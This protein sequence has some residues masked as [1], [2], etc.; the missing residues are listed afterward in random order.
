MGFAMLNVFFFFT[1]ALVV[2]LLRVI[3]LHVDLV[4]LT[5]LL[6]NF[7]VSCC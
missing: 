2:Q 5:F 7:S 3:G 4:S 6:F 1:G